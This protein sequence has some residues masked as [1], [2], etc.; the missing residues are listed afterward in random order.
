MSDTQVVNATPAEF[1]T[2]L[3]TRKALPSESSTELVTENDVPLELSTEHVAIYS[4][5]CAATIAAS[6][7][8]ACDSSNSLPACPPKS[9]RI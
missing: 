3:P 7:F 2:V 9:A 8:A 1:N 5:S 6:R 4:S